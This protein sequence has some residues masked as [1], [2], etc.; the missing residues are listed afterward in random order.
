VAR[1]DGYRNAGRDIPHGRRLIGGRDA[2]QC[3]GGFERDG[4]E[5]IVAAVDR[6]FRDARR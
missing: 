6:D 2:E 1:Q 5:V 3:P 4:L